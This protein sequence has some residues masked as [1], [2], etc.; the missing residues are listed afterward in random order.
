MFPAKRISTYMYEIETQEK[1]F[2][3]GCHLARGDPYY[4]SVLR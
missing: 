4:A 1:K 2:H 3:P